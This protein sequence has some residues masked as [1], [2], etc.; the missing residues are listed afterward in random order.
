MVKDGTANINQV[1]QLE[2]D[3]DLTEIANHKLIGESNLKNGNSKIEIVNGGQEVLLDHKI[4]S[5]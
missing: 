2:Q 1:E 4:Q 3:R 5:N